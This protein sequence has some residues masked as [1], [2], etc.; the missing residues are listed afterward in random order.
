MNQLSK[1]DM[2]K[3]LNKVPQVTL[4]FWIIKI[5]STTVGE[6]GADLLIYKLHWGLALTSLVMLVP[7]LAIVILQLREKRYVPWVYWSTVVMISIVGTLITDNLVDNLGVSLEVT[8]AA[9]SLLLAITFVTW[10]AQEKTLSINSID[11]P[12]RERYYWLAILFTFALG[13]A[14]GDW[15]AESMN[16]GYALSAAIFAGIIALVVVAHY[17]FKLG[18]VSAFW[19]AYILTRPFG[20]SCGDLLSKSVARGGMGWGTVSTSAVFLVV[21]VALVVYLSRTEKCQ[22]A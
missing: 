15:V 9:F 21:I 16:L 1:P 3:M 17:C 19:V 6:T 7:L 13:T 22:P 2:Q 12:K 14:A 11:T 8:S 4:I 18:A 20:A 10:Y 5:L